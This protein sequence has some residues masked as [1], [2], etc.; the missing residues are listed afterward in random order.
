M[1][2]ID[3]VK[4]E[5]QSTGHFSSESGTNYLRV[6]D[7]PH[8]WGA[9]FGE[10][11]MPQ[12][13]ARQGEFERAIVEII[14]KARYRCDVASLNCPDPDWSRAIL[15]AMDTALTKN[16]SRTQPTQFRFLFG[17]T[18]MA[19]LEYGKPWNL[20]DFMAALVRLVRA[21]SS[22]WE[23]M[24]EIW[25]G[26]F[27]QIKTGLFDS[28]AATY[29]PVSLYSE[30]VPDVKMTWNHSKI[31]AV[32]GSE[33]LVGGHNLNM[34]L[35]RSY[36]PVHDVSVVV[37]GGAAHGAQRFLNEMWTAGSNLLTKESLNASTLVWTDRSSE[38]AVPSDPLAVAAV[39]TY[40]AGRQASLVALHDSGQQTAVDPVLPVLPP[41]PPTNDV[42]AHDL[43]SLTDLAWDVFP[44]RVTY[45]RYEKFEEYKKAT[46]ILSVGKYW[47][48]TNQASDFKKGSELMKRN[49]ILNAQSTIRMSQMDLISAWKRN[50]SDHVVCQ[51]IIQALLQNKYLNVQVVVSPLDAGAGAEGDQYSFGSGATRTFELIRYYMTHDVAT[52]AL[53]PDPDGL[54]AHALDRFVIAPL[55]YTDQVPAN[56]RV[57]GVTYKWPNLTPE[58]Y[59]ATLKKSPLS[60]VAPSAGVIGDPAGSFVSASGKYYP[61]VE[62]APGNHAKIMIVDDELYVVGSDNLYPG[63]L[64][65]F[66]YL[67][68]GANAVSD[69]LQS[70]WEPLWRYS[71][72]NKITSAVSGIGIVSNVNFRTA[73][74][75]TQ[76]NGVADEPDSGE[77]M[78]TLIDSAGYPVPN[79][80]V[81]FERIT[82]YATLKTPTGTT[83]AQGQFASKV[84]DASAETATFRAKYLTGGVYKN[85]I[86]GSPASVAFDYPLPP[87]GT[88]G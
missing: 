17:Q 84:S 77:I 60:I 88:G 42:Q 85:V 4:A 14:Q 2:K 64:S 28:I 57:E 68:E 49:L 50:W 54:R 74:Q 62:S 81:L 48:G 25:I 11:I 38:P 55:F 27:Y 66:N 56:Q 35:F 76:P 52:D 44:E 63:N 23:R 87:I 18:P 46:R 59:T 80:P 24:P 26:R 33:A 51:W 37:H 45:D 72:P 73:I 67:V 22:Y 47:T 36:P 79:V 19:L 8:I 41:L 78:V 6:L 3:V 30:D 58:G 39:Q 10:A 70:Y 61:K 13:I 86:Y 40:V 5:L 69:L 20:V 65:E 1:S 32:D 53:L 16:M 31:I 12:A 7:T 15:G 34:D 9:P 75:A 29:L 21:R 82:G 83:N 43:R 71:S